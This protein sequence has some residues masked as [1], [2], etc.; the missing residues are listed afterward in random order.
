MDAWL[1]MKFLLVYYIYNINNRINVVLIY[2]DVYLL[3][4]SP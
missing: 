3:C 2:V 4:S 1:F